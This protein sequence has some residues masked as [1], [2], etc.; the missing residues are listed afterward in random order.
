LLFL[1]DI[2]DLPLAINGS[3][4][5]NPFSNNKSLIIMD[6][7]LHVLDSKQSANL[8]AIYNKKFYI[9]WDLGFLL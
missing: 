5:P 3:V 1:L 7:N 2:N 9:K 4:I 8:Y 6:K